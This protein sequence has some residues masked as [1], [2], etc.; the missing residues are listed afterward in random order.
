[1]L[2]LSLIHIF[3]PKVYEQESAKLTEENKVFVKG[4]V[5]AEEDK[6]GK[7][8]CESIQAFDDIRKTLWIKFPTMQEYETAEKQLM[9]TLAESDGNDGVVILSLIHI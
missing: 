5:S 2:W 3:F 6:D 8:I 9:E 4:R 1:M 7:I